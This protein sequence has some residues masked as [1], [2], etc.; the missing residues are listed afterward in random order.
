MESQLDQEDFSDQI[1]TEEFSSL[2]EEQKRKISEALKLYRKTNGKK[3][4]DTNRES[5]KSIESIKNQKSM[6]SEASKKQI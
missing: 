6:I 4:G 1:S 5:S 3:A 2:S